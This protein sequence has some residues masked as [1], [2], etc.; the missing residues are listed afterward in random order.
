MKR[1]KSASVAQVVGALAMAA[2]ALLPAR[3]AIVEFDFTATV[4]SG[5]FAGEVG[6]GLIR[7]DDAFGGTEVSPGAGNGS[8]EIDFTFRGQTFDEENDADFPAF[9]LVTR[10]GSQPVAI[11]FVLVNGVSG[12]DFSDAEILTVA[13]QGTLLPGNSS[14]LETTIDVLVG[15]PGVVPEPASFGLAGLALLGLALGRRRRA[16][17]R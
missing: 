16:A 1:S 4:A 13:L 3:A 7:F 8:L 5:P 6:S 11:D 17:P 12:V 2:A 15:D 14:R 10:V 9:P